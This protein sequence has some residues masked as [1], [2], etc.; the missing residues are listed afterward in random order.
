MQITPEVKEETV[1]MLDAIICIFILAIVIVAIGIW[2]KKHPIT[3]NIVNVEKIVKEDK[4]LQEVKRILS[5]TEQSKNYEGFRKKQGEPLR[6]II[7]EDYPFENTHYISS[8]MN[9]LFVILSNNA[10]A[11]EINREV[12]I[13]N[14]TY[15]TISKTENPS[16]PAFWD[17]LEEQEKEEISKEISKMVDEKE[18]HKIAQKI[19]GIITEGT[20][21]IACNHSFM[22]N[23]AIMYS[24]I[25]CDKY[26]VV[27]EIE[28][29]DVSETRYGS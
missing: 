20:N 21:K 29:G 13:K 2:F 8:V 14:P 18:A 24:G 5:W 4:R 25:N 12:L 15:F 22:Y 11:N 26:I 6:K 1:R 19:A 3:N 28:E 10:N 7:E 16:F 27:E 23:K 9:W 17:M